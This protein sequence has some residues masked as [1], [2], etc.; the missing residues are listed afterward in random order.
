MGNIKQGVQVVLLLLRRMSYRQADM[1][2]SLT[3]VAFLLSLIIAASKPQKTC[4]HQEP[5]AAQPLA[6]P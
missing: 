5:A 2:T 6:S 3:Q 4:N 1:V